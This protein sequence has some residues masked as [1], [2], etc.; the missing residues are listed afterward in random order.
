MNVQ[1]PDKECFSIGEVSEITQIQP[2]VLRYWENKCKLLRPSRRESG[3]RKFSRK[4]VEEILK[5]KDLLYMKGL[6]VMG[7]KKFL[8]QEKRVRPEQMKIELGE[9]SAAIELLKETKSTLEEVL[10]ILK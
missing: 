10:K 6:T 7:A 2:Y 5:V 4:D 8:I 3:H 1:F 9:N